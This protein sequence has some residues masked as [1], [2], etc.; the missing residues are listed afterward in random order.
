MYSIMPYNSPAFGMSRLKPKTNKLGL[1]NRRLSAI[2]LLDE[3]PY[4][5][6]PSS[7]VRVGTAAAGTWKSLFDVT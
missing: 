7:G 1:T 4:S 5:N 2:I 6:M 3:I